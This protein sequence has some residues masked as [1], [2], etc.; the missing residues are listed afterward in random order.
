MLKY[1]QKL[2]EETSQSVKK[3]QTPIKLITL[4]S[5]LNSSDET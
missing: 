2:I 3:F 5:T 4:A 1:I